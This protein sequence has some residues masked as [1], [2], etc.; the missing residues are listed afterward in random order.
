MANKPRDPAGE[1]V[2]PQRPWR[3]IRVRRFGRTE[4]TRQNLSIDHAANACNRRRARLREEGRAQEHEK[5]RLL[6]K[7]KLPG[8][9][10][11]RDH[12]KN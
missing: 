9:L 3:A 11:R 7:A 10:L 4:R 8:Q 5:M 2:A 6:P 1:R 12:T